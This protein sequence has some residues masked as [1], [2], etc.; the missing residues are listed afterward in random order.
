[1]KKKKQKFHLAPQIIHRERSE[2]TQS[3]RE[4]EREK[5]NEPPLFGISFFTRSFFNLYIPFASE[6]RRRQKKKN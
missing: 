5:K 4:R 2:R 3:E 6:R 1:M